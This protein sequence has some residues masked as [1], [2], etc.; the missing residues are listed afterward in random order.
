[1]PFDSSWMLVILA[2]IAASAAARG[3]GTPVRRW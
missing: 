3:E 1:V 2:V